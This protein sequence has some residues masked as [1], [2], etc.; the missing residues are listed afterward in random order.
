MYLSSLVVENDEQSF[1]EFL[2]DLMKVLVWKISTLL[3]IVLAESWTDEVDPESVVDDVS[4]CVLVFYVKEVDGI[5]IVDLIA[6]VVQM[7]VVVKPGGVGDCL[8]NEVQQEM[9]LQTLQVLITEHQEG[10]VLKM[11]TAKKWENLYWVLW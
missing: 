9:V 8:E 10:G 11:K 2:V 5:E 1:V 4:D 6:Q 3:K 7:V